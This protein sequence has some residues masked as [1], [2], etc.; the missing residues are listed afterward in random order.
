MAKRSR[1][2]AQPRPPTAN[3]T[4]YFPLVRQPE[5]PRPGP[6]A[7]DG[8]ADAPGHS[9]GDVS[10]DVAAKRLAMIHQL[11]SLQFAADD[12]ARVVQIP[13]SHMIGG[14]QA[15]TDAYDSGRLEG[16]AEVLNMLKELAKAGS[17]P[18]QKQYLELFFANKKRAD[19]SDASGPA[20]VELSAVRDHLGGLKLA[21]DDTSVVELARLAAMRILEL[22]GSRRHVR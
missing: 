2:P 12:I 18:A 20:S 11:A 15:A 22:E 21:P 4:T 14:D 17:G 3:Q 13:A 7:P 5:P 6:D 16:M 1:K 19:G 9:A 10:G 8:Q